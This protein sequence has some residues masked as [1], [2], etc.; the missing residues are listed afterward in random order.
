MAS[1]VVI[2]TADNR[3]YRVTET[4]STDLAHVWNG[5]RVKIVKG[6]VVDLKSARKE[7]VRKA[8]TN[9]VLGAFDDFEHAD[10]REFLERKAAAE[11]ASRQRL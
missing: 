3:L 6:E 1:T 11:N 5:V 7:L 10:K 8:Y 9:L 4:G 2:E